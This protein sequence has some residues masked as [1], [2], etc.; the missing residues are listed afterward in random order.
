LEA[1]S[2]V[3]GSFP[4]SAKN[5]IERRLHTLE[6]QMVEELVVEMLAVELD[7]LLSFLVLCRA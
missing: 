1:V 2:R 7:L 4:I 5:R 6:T 3:S